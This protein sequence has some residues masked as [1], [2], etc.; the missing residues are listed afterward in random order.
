VCEYVYVYVYV[1]VYMYMCASMCVRVHAYVRT[2]LRF[3]NIGQ[4]GYKCTY[5]EKK[6][7]IYN[8]ELEF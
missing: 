4:Y 5:E 8:R 3:N 6:T 2:R 7:V 1:C